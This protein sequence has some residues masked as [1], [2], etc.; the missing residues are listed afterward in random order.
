VR[1]RSE[2]EIGMCMT[3]L[4]SGS[5]IKKI[6]I[7]TLILIAV[8]V[9]I[10]P[11]AWVVSSS[12][13]P[14]IEQFRSEPRWVP[15]RPT[16]DNY[17]YVIRD[18]NFLKYLRNSARTALI[19]GGISV[20]CGGVAAYAIVRFRAFGSHAVPILVLVQRMAP[21]VMIAIPFF[22]LI[23][24]VN[25]IDT[26]FGLSLAHVSFNLPFA[27]WLL[28]GFFSD[29]PKEL[30]EAAWVDGCNRFQAFAKITLPLA[31]PGLA[32]TGVF[33][34]IQ[35]WNEFFFAVIVTR[36]TSSQ[37]LPIAVSSL[38]IP[39]VGI[40]YGKMAAAGILSVFPVMIFALA[41]QRHLV[42]GLTAGAVK[43]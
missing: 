31:A 13:K 16:L 1:L 29:I 30:E 15:E 18:M 32:A 10:L 17:A 28:M 11:I 19:S 41:I 20:I 3:G 12:F 38:V 7:Y 21:P 33:T 14:E 26:T 9:A 27:L 25:L 8:S 2:G 39:V 24:R 34:L 23:M 35:S 43:G 42:R 36:S 6:A 22:L 5:L 40:P 37:T 4:R